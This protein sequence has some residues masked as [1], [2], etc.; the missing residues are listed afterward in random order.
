M[1]C[2]HRQVRCVLKLRC[3][4]ALRGCSA[5]CSGCY[6]LGSLLM[7]L[8]GRMLRVKAL[9]GM[10]W[11][12]WVGLRCVS[13]GSVGCRCYTPTAANHVIHARLL[14]LSL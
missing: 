6:V 13:T 2:T 4:W 3:G 11:C 7:G 8:G 1:G 10:Y 14:V 12:R 5:W 9:Y